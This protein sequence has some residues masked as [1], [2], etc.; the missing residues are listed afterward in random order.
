M[1][2]ETL[3]SF[4]DLAKDAAPIVKQIGLDGV[5]KFHEMEQKGYF[6]LLNQAGKTFDQILSRYSIEDIQQ[7][8][9]NLV[10]AFDLLTNPG[11]LGKLNTAAKA[12]KDIDPDKIEEY[13]I[14]K[15]M[16]QMN[17]PE[18]KKSL[19]FMMAFINNIS[20]TGN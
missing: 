19:G 4:A 16:R 9:E 17:K 13:S 11:L 10:S 6:E 5:Q 18:V 8:S 15:L 7:L 2:M 12:L 14:W 3:E 1:V 20:K